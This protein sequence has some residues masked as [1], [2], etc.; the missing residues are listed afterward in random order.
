MKTPTCGK[1]SDCGLLDGGCCAL[2]LYGGRPSY[3]TCDQCK[4]NPAKGQMAALVAKGEPVQVRV[5]TTAAVAAATEARN[6]I[7]R[8]LWR[9]MHYTALSPGG[10]TEAKI[11]DIRRRLPCGPCGPNWDALRKA[12]PLPADPT[13]HFEVTWRWHNAVS[14]E[15]GKPGMVLVDAGK[16]YGLNR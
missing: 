11:A 1:W 16:L 13:L 8:G 4:E 14:K 9:E 3:G 2:K 6:A 15:L 7:F 10:L 12:D 5:P